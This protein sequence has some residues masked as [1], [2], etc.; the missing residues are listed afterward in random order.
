MEAADGE[1]FFIIFICVVSL[2][3]GRRVGA[4]PSTLEQSRDEREK[5]NKPTTS[6]SFVSH[7]EKSSLY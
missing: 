3:G 2:C 5:Q 6:S 1:F 7:F 4:P